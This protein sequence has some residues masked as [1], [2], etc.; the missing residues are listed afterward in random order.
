M[1]AI[2]KS[3]DKL[4]EVLAQGTDKVREMFEMMAQKTQEGQ[5]SEVQPVTTDNTPPVET[6]IKEPESDSKPVNSQT[7]ATPE[8]DGNEAESSEKVDIYQM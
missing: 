6:G 7:E 1:D 8:K 4:P 5:E 3:M 2:E